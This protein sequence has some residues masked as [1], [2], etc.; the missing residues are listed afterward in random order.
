MVS[1]IFL[2]TVNQVAVIYVGPGQ[3][4]KNSI[5]S[6]Q[7]GIVLWRLYTL[8]NILANVLA[9]T[10]WPLCRTGVGDLF[11]SQWPTRSG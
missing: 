2:E 1:G 6:N 10:C 11:G 8:A 7:G 4:D 5:L 3:E 9:N